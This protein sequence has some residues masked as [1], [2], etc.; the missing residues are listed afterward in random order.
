MKFLSI[1][2]PLMRM[3][4]LVVTL[5]FPT[6][7][8]LAQGQSFRFVYI[9][10]DEM[11]PVEKLQSNLDAVWNQAVNGTPTVFYLSR[12]TEMPLIVK[13]GIEGDDNRE[14]YEK[15]L[16]PSITQQTTYRVD[17]KKDVVHIMELLKTN[18]FLDKSGNPLF[19]ETNFDFHVGQSFWNSTNNEVVIAALFFELNIQ[20]YTADNVKFNVHVP[21][22]LE[23]DKNIGPFGSLNP[24]DC[25]R[26][27][28]LD[29]IY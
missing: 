20:R 1:K 17:G 25:S 4:C 24:D 5:W 9:A 19:K 2:A 22:D 23:F 3:L 13:V 16:I 21:R 12:G 8:L 15:E 27:I 14:E 11:T 26:S 6:V 29:R 28:N 10:Q 7:L 18:D